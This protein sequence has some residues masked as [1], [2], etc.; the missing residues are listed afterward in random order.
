MEESVQKPV[1]SYNTEDLVEDVAKNKNDKVKA[2][3]MSSNLVKVCSNDKISN[4]SVEHIACNDSHSS[5]DL[6]DD[7]PN[8]NSD[9]DNCEIGSS[10]SRLYAE[11]E[12]TSFDK[13]AISL[14]GDLKSSTTTGESYK[15][16]DEQKTRNSQGKT[17]NNFETVLCV[18]GKESGFSSNNSENSILSQYSTED[19]KHTSAVE[20]SINETR[21]VEKDNIS[22]LHHNAQLSSIENEAS[23]EKTNPNKVKQGAKVILCDNDD[24]TIP[25]AEETL[26]SNACIKCEDASIVEGAIQT[27][28]RRDT[29]LD[30]ALN[31]TT[32]VSLEE[33][34]CKEKK[35]PYSCTTLS[36]P[37]HDD[38]SATTECK[39]TPDSLCETTC[40]EESNTDQQ[41]DK[42]NDISSMKSQGKPEHDLDEIIECHRMATHLV[43]TIHEDMVSTIRE[44]IVTPHDEIHPTKSGSKTDRNLEEI[45][46][47]QRMAQNV[48]RTVHEEIVINLCKN[49]AQQNAIG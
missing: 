23:E 38:S 28:F 10:E 44:E 36:N 4:L 47:C 5:N 21:K 37:S 11:K 27:I 12:D 7:Y 15:V 2:M 19:I 24:T 16:E 35:I 40:G 33:K 49:A 46:E 25:S 17:I 22:T 34:I 13:T 18:S 39:N 29:P 30:N 43:S 6:V 20:T 3:F 32:N 42:P 45:V 41:K 14:E 26:K 31:V 9:E 8:K 48:V 1:D